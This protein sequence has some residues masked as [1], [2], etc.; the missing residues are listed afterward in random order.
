MAV[1]LAPLPIPPHLRPLRHL[2]HF[3]PGH[4][5]TTAQPNTIACASR[6][7]FTAK[8]GF[9]GQDNISRSLASPIPRRAERAAPGCTPTGPPMPGYCGVRGVSPPAGVGT[10]DW[11]PVRGMRGTVVRGCARVQACGASTRLFAAVSGR[12]RYDPAMNPAGPASEPQ[13]SYGPP[14]TT[15]YRRRPRAARTGHR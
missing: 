7:S 13:I 14:L 4:K 15:Y 6:S 8:C 9:A 10:T 1:V 3:P 11:I 2:R 12:H 5:P